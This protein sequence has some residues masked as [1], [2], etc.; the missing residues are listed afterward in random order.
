MEETAAAAAII[1][2]VPQITSGVCSYC[3]AQLRPNQL[4]Q[5]MTT[6]LTPWKLLFPWKLST[7]FV[8]PN[9]PDMRKRKEVL[10]ILACLE[11]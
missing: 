3:S 2:V 9:S 5:T 8:L 11:T 1:T 7:Y 4:V 6:T 10:T